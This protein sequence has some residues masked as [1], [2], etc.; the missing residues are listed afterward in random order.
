[1]PCRTLTIH[2]P[3]QRTVVYSEQALSRALPHSSHSNHPSTADGRWSNQW[4]G[5]VACLAT[6]K[7]SVHC[8]WTMVSTVGRPCRVPCRT[9]T[10]LSIHPLSMDDAHHGLVGL[11]APASALFLALS[12]YFL[13]WSG[14]IHEKQECLS[15]VCAASRIH[16]CLWTVRSL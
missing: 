9:L 11:Q 13:V 15:N 7:P 8:R 1:M 5:P 16:P 6:L 12:R 10:T 2:Q 4:A 14:Q 3:C